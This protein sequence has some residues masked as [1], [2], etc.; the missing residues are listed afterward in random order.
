MHALG[1][2]WKYANDWP[3]LTTKGFQA[4]LLTIK[5]GQSN[6][7]SFTVV[8]RPCARTFEVR[9]TAL[10]HDLDFVNDVCGYH[11]GDLHFTDY[12]V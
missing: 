8:S 12:I 7:L 3:T 9:E 4:K 2:E 1:Y 10:L 6:P 11:I 5:R